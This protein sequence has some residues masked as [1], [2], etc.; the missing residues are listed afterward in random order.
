MYYCNPMAETQPYYEQ[1][2]VVKNE[3]QPDPSKEVKVESNKLGTNG[4]VNTGSA[5]VV[6][7]PRS[8]LKLQQRK[9]VAMRAS[10]MRPSNCFISICLWR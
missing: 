9:V 7:L 5:F 2:P 10:P 1:P 3:A 6:E 4:H 8:P